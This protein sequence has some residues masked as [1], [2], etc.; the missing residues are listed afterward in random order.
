MRKTRCYRA[1][2]NLDQDL[3][4]DF[5][6]SVS[7]FSDGTETKAYLSKGTIY[8]HTNDGVLYSKLEEA[9]PDTFYYEDWSPSNDCEILFTNS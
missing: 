4:T 5:L 8:V 7:V 6:G 2:R 9:F 1:K 3:F